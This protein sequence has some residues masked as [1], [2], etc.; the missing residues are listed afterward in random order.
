M[1]L[2]PPVGLADVATKHDLEQLE[3]RLTIETEALGHRLT[4]KIAES[5]RRLLVAMVTTMLATVIA[6]SG[7]AFAAVG[8]T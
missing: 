5:E 6:V 7:L 8:L 2:L 4:T 1:S 3:P